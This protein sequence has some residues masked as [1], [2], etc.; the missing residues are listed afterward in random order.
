LNLAF[1]MFIDWFNPLGNKISAQ[2][3]SMGIIVL[4][5]MNLPLEYCYQAQN[6][7]LCGVVPTPGQPNMTTISHIL[8]PLIKELLYLDAD[9]V[10]RSHGG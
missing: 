2:Q 3:V 10:E 7:Y 1:S 9:S 5:C 4:T 8:K 6:M